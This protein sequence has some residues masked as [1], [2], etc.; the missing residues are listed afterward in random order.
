MATNNVPVIAI[1]SHRRLDTLQKHTLAFLDRSGVPRSNVY[2]FV[3][4]LE[5]KEAY[6]AIAGVNIVYKHKIDTLREKFNFIRRWFDEGQH[7]FV[8]EDDISTIVE[9]VEANKSVDVTKFDRFLMEGF[10][11][12]E[13]CKARIWGISPHSNAFYMSNDNSINFKFIVAHAFGLV[14][15][16]DE[17]RDITLDG[18][19]DYERTILYYLADGKTPR[20]NRFGVKA[21]ASYKGAGGLQ[22]EFASGARVQ[23][24]KD[25]VRY[26]TTRYELLCSENLTKKSVMPE[27][28]LRPIKSPHNHVVAQQQKVERAL[29]Y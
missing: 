8:I 17:R 12:M 11:L 27:L 20:L 29:G 3:S 14:A 7:I 28:K 9:K 19:S 6:D 22:S 15:D 10:A 24:E 1:P 16:K 5:D 21:I 23:K 25:A 26:L 13:A 18:K 2:V 4:D